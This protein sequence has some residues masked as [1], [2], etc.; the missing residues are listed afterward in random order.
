[1]V[2]TLLTFY[3]HFRIYCI[4]VALAAGITAQFAFFPPSPPTYGLVVA[5]GGGPDAAVVGVQWNPHASS[6]YAELVLHEL[7]V[8][9]RNLARCGASC[10]RLV[11]SQGAAVPA[12]YFAPRS[13]SPQASARSPTGATARPLG[14]VLVYAHGNA[15]DLGMLLPHLA[16]LRDALGVAVLAAEYTGY[17]PAEGV[18]SVAGA[19]E[20]VEAAV[21]FA[22]QGLGFSPPQVVLYGQSIGSGPCCAAAA[23]T[24]GGAAPAGAALKGD[25]GGGRQGRLGAVV[26]HSPIASG[27]RTMTAPGTCAPSQMC[28]CLDPFNNVARVKELWC[29][30]LVMHGTRDEVVPHWHGEMLLASKASA[31]ASARRARWGGGVCCSSAGSRECYGDKPGVGAGGGAAAG[32]AGVAD[33]GLFVEGA[34]HANLVEALGPRFFDELR[35]FLSALPNATPVTAQPD[36]SDPEQTPAAVTAAQGPQ[37][38]VPPLEPKAPEKTLELTPRTAALSKSQVQPVGEA[39][40]AAA[41]PTPFAPSTRVLRRVIS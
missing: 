14:L 7:Y 2:F 15:T 23:K 29:P 18:P 13:A 35:R 1:M 9:F 30:L 20:A 5:E 22:L 38:R 41:L 12:F 33:V 40:T 28:F 34:G 26:L 37:L 36:A 6:A 10:Y 4:H 17:G 31:A 11:T 39:A 25:T 16:T 19:T 21:G 27:L 32:A 24:W 3:R 8:P